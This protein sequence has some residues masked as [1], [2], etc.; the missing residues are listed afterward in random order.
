MIRRVCVVV[1]A[2]STL[3][4][5]SAGPA[6]AKDICQMAGAI[7]AGR[8]DGK[9]TPAKQEDLVRPIRCDERL[10]PSSGVAVQDRT[11]VRLTTLD[12][13]VLATLKGM[14]LAGNWRP[15][16]RVAVQDRRE[17]RYELDLE[18]GAWSRAAA[19]RGDQPSDWPQLPPPRPGATGHWSWALPSASSD[20]RLAQWSG[21]CETRHAYFIG[22]DGD[23]IPL[24][25]GAAD[26]PTP[27][28]V[29]L[30]WAPD[31]RAVIAV[32]GP[33][34]C[35]EHLPVPGVYLVGLDRTR[36]LVASGTDAQMWSVP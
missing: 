19:P 20:V 6:G 24:L 12:G 8:V 35:G 17:R 2:A 10:I 11:G 27:Q 28:S 4:L 31:G 1:L 22:A 26:A 3:M 9:I 16:L 29:A 23:V 21:E 36:T 18:T 33:A 30:G 5:S 25:E 14:S 7:K 15:W 34:A 13:R 32:L